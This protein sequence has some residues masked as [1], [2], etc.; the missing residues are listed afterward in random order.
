MLMSVAQSTAEAGGNVTSSALLEKTAE[1]ARVT[2]V[3]RIHLVT[4]TN[5]TVRQL[6]GWLLSDLDERGRATAPTDRAHAATVCLQILALPVSVTR[7]LY[8]LEEQATL[9]V[10]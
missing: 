7:I 5:V 10:D 1:N 2:G 8:Y 4:D 6:F 3:I 9:S